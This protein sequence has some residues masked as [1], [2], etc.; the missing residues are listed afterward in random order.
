MNHK[1]AL[2][3]NAVI[4]RDIGPWGWCNNYVRLV[5]SWTPCQLR[6]VSGTPGHVCTQSSISHAHSIQ[7]TKHLPGAETECVF[8]CRNKLK[9]VSWLTL[10][11]MRYR[12]VKLMAEKIIGS[13]FTDRLQKA[14]RCDFRSGLSPDYAITLLRYADKLI[15][16]IMKVYLETNNLQLELIWYRKETF[17]LFTCKATDSMHRPPNAN[18][19]K[20]G[21]Q[22]TSVTVISER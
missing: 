18:I 5:I 14:I 16:K 22:S 11:F 4:F 7:T 6:L 10:S 2:H 9:K 19:W 15:V 8:N 17:T 3:L 1:L 12:G 20:F 13:I 21:T